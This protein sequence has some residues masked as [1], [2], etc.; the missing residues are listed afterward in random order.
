MID[1][2]VDILNEEEKKYPAGEQWA[3]ERDKELID[4]LKK[5]NFNVAVAM[6]VSHG[7]YHM[8]LA[9]GI[10]VG[11]SLMEKESKNAN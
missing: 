2:T 5:S 9:V 11:I 4:L 6:A 3:V 1:L 8:L 10:Y 7:N